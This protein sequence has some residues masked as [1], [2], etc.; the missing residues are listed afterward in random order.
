MSRVKPKRILTKSVKRK[1]LMQGP[2][3]FCS[4]H[5]LFKMFSQCLRLDPFPHLEITPDRFWNV[6]IAGLD[7]VL[8]RICFRHEIAIAAQMDHASNS[9]P[10]TRFQ[11]SVFGSLR[12]DQNLIL[13]HSRE[14]SIC[15]DN[16]YNWSQELYDQIN[17]VENVI[18]RHFARE[19]SEIIARNENSM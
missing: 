11:L 14:I 8:L 17:T 6:I 18:Y 19:R 7:D 13:L 4:D 1:T 2:A 3:E 12:N 10:V 5:V 15:F 16:I 9:I